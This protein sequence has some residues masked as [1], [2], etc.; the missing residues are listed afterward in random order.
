MYLRADKKHASDIS[1]S[2]PVGVDREGNEISVEDVIGENEEDFLDELDREW[3][4]VNLRNKI[5][6]Y[7]NQREQAIISLRYGLMNGVEKTQKDVGK[8]LGISRSYVSRLEKSALNKLRKAF[9][10]SPL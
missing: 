4:A 3:G 6:A 8:I 9:A 5:K 10:K 1:L 2:E 7:L